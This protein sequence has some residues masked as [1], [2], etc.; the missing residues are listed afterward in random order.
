[1]FNDQQHKHKDGDVPLVLSDT[2]P[3]TFLIMLE[4]IYTNCATL[5][6]K[7]VEQN[8]NRYT[9]HVLY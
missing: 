4:F 1:M 9:V 5:T 6:L 8:F 7:T 3:E 2:S